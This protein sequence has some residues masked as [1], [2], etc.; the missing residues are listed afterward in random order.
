MHPAY[1]FHGLTIVTSPLKSLI[2]DQLR[3]CAIHN[4]GASVLH[5]DLSD[6]EQQGIYMC[7]KQPV[8][9]F[10]ILYVL[11]EIIEKDKTFFNILTALYSRNKLNLFVVDEA[12]CVSMWGNE[13]RDSYL[14]LS[15][16]RKS[17]K[18]VPLL[19][20][21]ATASR[22]T[23]DDISILG[24]KNTT[25]IFSPMDRG[26]IFCEVRPKNV[27]VGTW[28]YVQPEKCVVLTVIQSNKSATK[29]CLTF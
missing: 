13:F 2:D 4:I 12:H 24:A 7:L 17:F 8:S 3:A 25:L 21:T 9:P 1:K 19:I 26:N 23:R 11:P 20:M 18:N 10:K 16:L 29:F 22:N 28:I 27:V 15:E 6:S 5:G 14:K